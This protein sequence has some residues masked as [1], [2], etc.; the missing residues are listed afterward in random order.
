MTDPINT[1]SKPRP[2]ELAVDMKNVSYVYNGNKV[3]DRVNLELPAGEYAVVLGP[4]GGGKTTLIKLLMGLYRPQAGQIRVLGKK[5]GHDAR[6]I[7]YLQQN[8]NLPVDFPVTVN[9]LV[10]TGLLS[11]GGLGLFYSKEDH[12]AAEQ[13]MSRLGMLP[14]RERRLGALSGGQRQRA[15]LARAIVSRPR[16][17]VLDEPT[18]NVDHEGKEIL[19]NFLASLR[20]DTTIIMVSHDLNLIPSAASSIL[21]VNRS[22]YHHKSAEI[23]PGMMGF[24]H[25]SSDCCTCPVEMVAHGRP[26]L[27]LEDHK[28]DA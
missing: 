7:G 26:H 24:I 18:S 9:E 10:L 16:L 19:L 28:L 3:L 8:F 12:Q 17:L 4:N 21:C 2:A 25:G 1:L 14:F 6:H 11:R 20:G 22:L 27:I 13:A 5:P 15:Y 23:T